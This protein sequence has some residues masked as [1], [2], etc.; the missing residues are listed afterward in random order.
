MAVDFGGRGYA[1]IDSKLGDSD[2]GA[3]SGSLIDHFLETLAREGNFN[4]HARVLS[5]DNN[6]HRAEALFK[7]LA[8]AIRAALTVDER[9][10]GRTPSTKG[11]IG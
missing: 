5:G 1:V 11:K 8:R 2:L 3:L 7:A 6:H 9:L 4:L 10:S